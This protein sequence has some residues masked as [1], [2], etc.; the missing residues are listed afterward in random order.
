MPWEFTEHHIRPEVFFWSPKAYKERNEV[1]T[2]RQQA[3]D[4]YVKAKV[5]AL[6]Q[7]SYCTRYVCARVLHS[8]CMLVDPQTTKSLRLN[9]IQ[10]TAETAD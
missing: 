3:Q 7:S 4:A 8:Y 6:S 1:K 9:T 10:Q 2:R 5:I